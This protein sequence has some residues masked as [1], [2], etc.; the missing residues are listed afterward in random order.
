MSKLTNHLLSAPETIDYVEQQV[1]NLEFHLYEGRISPNYFQI[2][3]QSR[4]KRCKY[5]AEFWIIGSSHVVIIETE[6]NKLTE[7]VSADQ[8][9]LPS[10]SRIYHMAGLQNDQFCYPPYQISLELRQFDCLT[11]FEK[12]FH[13]L[14]DCKFEFRL[15]QIFPKTKLNGTTSEQHLPPSTIIDIFRADEAVLD[16]RTL[17]TYTEE[18]SIAITNTQIKFLK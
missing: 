2:F 6:N 10:D 18:M 5:E 4:L 12:E 3:R 13:Q 1:S 8:G 17:H 16:F 9:I 11:P 7:I 14:V 15:Q